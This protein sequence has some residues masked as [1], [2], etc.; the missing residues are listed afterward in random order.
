MKNKLLIITLISL[1]GISVVLNI[2]NFIRV[3]L[4]DSQVNELC[5]AFV[6]SA[7]T[8]VKDRILEK[9]RKLDLGEEKKYKLNLPAGPGHTAFVVSMG[10]LLEIQENEAGVIERVSIRK[11]EH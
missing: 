10:G 4:L 7:S 11:I 9:G 6:G 8:P 2:R 3:T 1:L 5:K